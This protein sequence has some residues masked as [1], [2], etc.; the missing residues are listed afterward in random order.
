[1]NNACKQCGS[2]F[3][4]ND[5]DLKSYEKVSPK[6]NGKKYPIPAPDICE[7]CREQRRLAFRNEKTLYKRECDLCSKKI[8]TTYHPDA[9]FTVYCQDCFWSDKWSALDHGQDYDFG[10]PFFDQ[11]AG[12]MKKAPRLALVNKQSENSEYCNYSF[13]NKNCYLTFGNHYEEDCMYGRYS[14]KNKDCVDYFWLYKSELCYECIFSGD[15]YKCVHLDHCV[16][17]NECYFSFDLRGCKNCLFSHGLRNKQYFIFN[18][19][20]SKKEYEEYFEKL[21]IGSYKQWRKLHEGW[22]K[23][24]K[25]KAVFRANYQ[26]NCEDCEGNN[27]QNSKNLKHCFSCS[28]CEDSAYG[29]QMDETYDSIDNSHMG[30]D[31]CELCYQ[32]IGCSGIFHCLCCDSCWDNSELSYCNMCFS[33]K[34]CFGCIGMRHNQYCIFNKQYS[35][36][37]YEEMVPRIVEHME[38][39][40]E[41]GQFFPIEIAPFAYNESVAIEYFDMERDVVL[42]NGWKWREDVFADLKGVVVDD[43]EDD[44][45]EMGNDVCKKVLECEISKR[46]FKITDAEFKFYE[47]LGVPVPRRCPDQRQK[48]RL[49]LANPWK[50]W[51][52]KCDKCDVNIK[53]SFEPSRPE[54]V[55]CEECYL[56][57]VK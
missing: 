55:Y 8:V 44:I 14:T 15:L 7:H 54:K 33:S 13:G 18:K 19:E 1:M 36:E 46:H 16:D 20:H 22:E 4:I 11:F 23:H 38:K 40:G 25:E 27:L 12:F 56:K 32:D 29:F 50:L 34:D 53:T 21:K 42:K 45:S 57:E 28:G 6:F 47:K 26:T 9:D 17:C 5:E 37:E 3:E 35:K 39:N 30:Y 49:E 24:K 10:K 52:R 2:Q 41:W 48:D 43:L 31:K 51:D